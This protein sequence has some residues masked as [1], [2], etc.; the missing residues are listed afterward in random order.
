[1][2]IDSVL[3][4]FQELRERGIQFRLWVTLSD[5]WE[6]F[7]SDLDRNVP[8]SSVI[9]GGC[10]SVETNLYRSDMDWQWDKMD[11]WTY[12]YKRPGMASYYKWSNICPL[13]QVPGLKFLNVAF[14]NGRVVND[15]ASEPGR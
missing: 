7:N 1:M 15:G 12:T 9:H 4:L 5:K 2:L 11:T 14:Q 6:N 10:K 8:R 3:F 13:P